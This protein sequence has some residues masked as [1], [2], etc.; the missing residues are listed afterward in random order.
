VSG[1][2]AAMLAAAMAEEG[3]AR[4][5]ALGVARCC[6]PPYPEMVGLMWP[7]AVRVVEAQRMGK[8]AARKKKTARQIEAL[9]VRQALAAVDEVAEGLA[10]G[11][12]R[13]TSFRPGEFVPYRV[14]EWSLTPVARPRAR[15]VA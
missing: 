11:E 3:Y 1:K 10:G 4:L 14:G 12:R 6:L 5:E 8:R 9:L 7:K 13:V 15:E 2:R